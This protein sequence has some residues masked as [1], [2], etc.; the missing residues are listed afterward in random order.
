MTSDP[1]LIRASDQDRDRTANLLREHHAVG[2]LD[3]DEFHDRLDRV[4]AAKTLGDLEELTADLPAVDPYPL[5]TS[6]LPDHYRGGGGLPASSVLGAMSRGQGRF[7]PAW[8]AAWGSWFGVSLLVIVIWLLTGMGY[9]WPLWVIGP[10]GAIMA[11]RWIVGAHPQGH[12][13]PP[14][15]GGGAGRLDH[16]QLGPARS[17]Q[18]EPK[19]PDRDGSTPP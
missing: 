16:D 15:V 10:W 7:S 1:K 6:S 2:R 4:F 14:G 17:D 19:H 8:Q 11:G 13:T 5:P 18:P 12:R 9:P 3:A